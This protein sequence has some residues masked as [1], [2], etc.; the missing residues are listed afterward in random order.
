MI[1]DDLK[2]RMQCVEAMKKASKSMGF[3]RRTFEF[4]TLKLNLTSHN[5]LVRPLLDY[6]DQFW[7][8][9]LKR[10]KKRR[11]WKVQQRGTQIIPGERNKSHETRLESLTLSNLGKILLRGDRCWLLKLWHRQFYPSSYLIIDQSDSIRNNGYNLVGKLFIMNQEEYFFFN[12]SI[13]NN[14]S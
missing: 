10:K 8:P 14:N 5:L 4:I 11:M 13:T 1:L 3:I 9:Y 12:R 6:Y 7:S 2:L